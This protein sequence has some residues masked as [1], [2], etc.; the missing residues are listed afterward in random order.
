M[1]P[2]AELHM[3]QT[4]RAFLRRSTRGLG[5]IALGS[6]LNVKAG[7]RNVIGSPAGLPHFE[8]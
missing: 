6:L 1:N 5:S 8:S 2:L 3:L 4:R 7:K